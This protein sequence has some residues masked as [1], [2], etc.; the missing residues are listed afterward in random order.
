MTPTVNGYSTV[1]INA[2]SVT[3]L[4]GTNAEII[5]AYDADTASTVILDGDVDIEVSD[6]ITHTEANTLNGKT[7]GVITATLSTTA[8]GDLD[9]LAGTGNA[10]TITV[11]T[12]SSNS[13]GIE[14][15]K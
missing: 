15:S 9:D 12:A 8:I 4:T 14:N 5:A 2:N 6:N 11:N 3:T 10:Y 7:T 1:A 13:C